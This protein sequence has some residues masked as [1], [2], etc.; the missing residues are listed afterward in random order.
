M[1]LVLCLVAWPVPP[2]KLSG[3]LWAVL[4]G[5]LASG[6]GYALWYAALRHLTAMTAAIV[7][8]AVP[9]LAGAGGV[10]LLREEL[11]GRLAFAAV[12]V[13]GGIAMAILGRTPAR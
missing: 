7:Q 12:L 2:V 4:S 3:V 6:I 8:L 5:A 1:A 11:T 10:I 13:L 9:I